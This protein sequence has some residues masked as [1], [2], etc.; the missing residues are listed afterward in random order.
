MTA[1]TGMVN[2]LRRLRG[3]AQAGTADYSVL[4]GSGGT[5]TFWSDDQL[6]EVI[7]IYRM[8]YNNAELHPVQ[9]I[10]TGG[11]ALY[12]QYYAPSGNLEEN[13]SG[14]VYFNIID[15]VG[16]AIGT[17]TYS[18]DYVTGLIRFNSNTEGTP[19]YWSGRSYNLY[20]AAADVW[21]QK[22]GAVSDAF[23]FKTDRQSFSR[24][25]R[26]DH[27][28]KMATYFDDQGGVTTGIKTAKM[29]RGD[30]VPKGG[31]KP[32]VRTDGFVLMEE[33]DD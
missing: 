9:E 3:Y 17:A 19:Y 7:D 11:S 31:I 2:L 20:A 29:T 6:Q 21:R 10:G 5:V 8:D 15:G 1:R 33:D 12:V 26:F 16:S 22:A 25:Q 30:L 14:T 18:V 13:T 24:A 23:D 28:M 32:Y 4:D 27:A